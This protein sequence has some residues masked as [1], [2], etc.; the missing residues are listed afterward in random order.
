L[1][2]VDDLAELIKDPAQVR[3]LTRLRKAIDDKFLELR[4]TIELQR[5][6]SPGAAAASVKEGSGK[7]L[8]DEVRAVVEEMRA[9]QVRLLE[10]YQARAETASARTQFSTVVSFL[11]RLASPAACQ[12]PAA[13]PGS[14][15]H[16]QRPAICAR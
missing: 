16:E 4:K 2:A 9:A 3:R 5:G 15:S 6:G 11:V 13:D 8:M 1:P 10:G 7:R 12:D 14:R